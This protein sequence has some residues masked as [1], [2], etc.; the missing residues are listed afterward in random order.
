[1]TYSTTNTYK[2]K[3]EILNFAKKISS[4]LHR[5]EQKFWIFTES[6]RNLIFMYILWHRKNTN[7]S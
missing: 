4:G 2:M 1:M 5:P 7:R 6:C 3:Q